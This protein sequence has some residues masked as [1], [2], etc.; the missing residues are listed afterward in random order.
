MK[1][2]LKLLTTTTAGIY[3]L[4]NN[5]RLG[6]ADDGEDDNDGG[7]LD[8]LYGK[9]LQI[10]D[11]SGGYDLLLNLMVCVNTCTLLFLSIKVL[12]CVAFRL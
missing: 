2:D 10:F 12:C 7:G 6:G 3:S 8:S 9:S 4:F 11:E 1:S 5:H